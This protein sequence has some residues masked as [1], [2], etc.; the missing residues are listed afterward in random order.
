MSYEYDI[1]I[2]HSDYNDEKDNDLNKWAAN[3]C[4]YLSIVL[5]RLF[6]RKPVLLLH[7]DLRS[8]Q[9]LFG[10][11]IQEIFSKTALFIT[12]LSPESIK[13]ESYIKELEIIKNNAASQN[14][15]NINKRIFKVLTGH[16]NTEEQPEFLQNN[17]SF[18]FFEINRFNKKSKTFNL[19]TDDP[20][21]KFW[22]KLIDLAYDILSELNRVQDQ[23]LTQNENIKKDCVFLAETSIDLMENRDIIRRELQHLGYNVLPLND[24][25]TDTERLKETI[26]SYLDQSVLSIHLMGSFYGVPLKKTQFSMLDLQ[27]QIVKEYIDNK[28]SNLERLIWIPNDLKPAEQRQNLYLNRLKRDDNRLKTEII[29]APLEVFKTIIFSKLHDKKN[30]VNEEN[31][32]P[33][34]YLI[35][36]NESDSVKKVKDLINSRNYNLMVSVFN[37]PEFNPVEIHR[38]FLIKADGVLICKG[39]SENQWVDSKLR[40]LIKAP[41]YGK[42]SLFKSVGLMA[43]EEIGQKYQNLDDILVI[44]QNE[45]LEES[46]KPF[47][48]KLS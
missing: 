31:H 5:Y 8:R 34:I 19:D 36:E 33:N 7:D 22:S 12:I 43:D 40:D 16:I 3:F 39:N 42:P 9:K 25:P 46:L 20:D 44:R 45:K 18:N 14:Q 37:S 41:G 11:N 35:Y 38:N 6:N 23:N 1:F 2:S 28:T 32:H 29:E 4:H 47:F 48:D 26:V 10:E 15:D 13:Q 21:D 17:L 30:K 27:N 24:L